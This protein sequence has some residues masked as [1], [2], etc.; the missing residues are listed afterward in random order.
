LDMYKY[1]FKKFPY[2]RSKENIISQSKFIGASVG[3]KNAERFEVIKIL[4]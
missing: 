3:Y 4:N 2:P 1:E